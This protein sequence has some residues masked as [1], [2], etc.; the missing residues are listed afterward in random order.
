MKEE[1]CVYRWFT[2]ELSPTPV[3]GNNEELDV[4]DCICSEKVHE[5]CKY[6]KHDLGA[7]STRR[8]TEGKNINDKLSLDN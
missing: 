2:T 1:Q 5:E 3:C 6:K 4:Y 7:Q 8:F